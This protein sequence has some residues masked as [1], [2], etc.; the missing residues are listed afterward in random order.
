MFG[1]VART[2]VRESEALPHRI[3]V[4][5]GRAVRMDPESVKWDRDV[6]ALLR[7]WC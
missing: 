3:S 5:T 7:D 2:R 1:L 4:L 6:P